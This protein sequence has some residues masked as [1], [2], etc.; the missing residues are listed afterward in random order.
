[1]IELL[2]MLKLAWKFQ[3]TFAGTSDNGD[4]VTATFEYDEL[5]SY[6]YIQETPTLF[7]PILHSSSDQLGDRLGYDM[8]V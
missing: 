2:G 1:M 7:G 5:P 6:C 4:S 8:N 3:G